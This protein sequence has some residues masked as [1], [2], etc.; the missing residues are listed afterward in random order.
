MADPSPQMSGTAKPELS[1]QLQRRES[2]PEAL[3]PDEL[4]GVVGGI[5]IIGTLFRNQNAT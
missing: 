1:M 2:E 4:Q 3:T 5:A